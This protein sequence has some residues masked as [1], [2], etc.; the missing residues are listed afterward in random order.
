MGMRIRTEREYLIKIVDYKGN[1]I[2]SLKVPRTE[3]EVERLLIGVVRL[4]ERAVREKFLTKELKKAILEIIEI[5]LETKIALRFMIK[6][7]PMLRNLNRIKREIETSEDYEEEI[8][9][10]KERVREVSRCSICGVELVEPAYIVYKKKGVEVER[11]K[12]IGIKCLNSIYGRLT[13]IIEE[14]TINW[15]Y[16][17][18][19]KK[20]S[21]E[22]EPTVEVDPVREVQNVQTNF[23]SME[24][25][26]VQKVQ[27]DIQVKEDSESPEDAYMNVIGAVSDTEPDSSSTEMVDTYVEMINLPGDIQNIQENTVYEAFK[28]LVAR[29]EERLTEEDVSEDLSRESKESDISSQTANRE[30]VEKNPVIKSEKPEMYRNLRLF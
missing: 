19:K 15:G 5:Y 28:D 3:S 21:K 10:E 30:N 17:M 4:Y 18:K 6:N 14:I 20:S 27:E 12:P 26:F 22:T 25:D 8:M 7:Y 11:S 23:V 13:N 29:N 9:Y 1:L 2:S 24:T 16:L